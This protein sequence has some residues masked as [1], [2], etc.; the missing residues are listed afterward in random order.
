MS[1][2][3]NIS[4]LALAPNF[5]IFLA[6]TIFNLYCLI[7]AIYHVKRNPILLILILI[8]IIELFEFMNL[9]IFQLDDR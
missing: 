7:F 5:L 4:L 1:I 3:I 9:L 8:S 2:L 6:I